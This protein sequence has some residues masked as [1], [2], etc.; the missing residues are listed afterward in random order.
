M[1]TILVVTEIRDGQLKNI[2]YEVFAAANKLAEKTN[3]NV[4]A[5]LLGSNLSQPAEIPGKY[6]VKQVII[7]ELEVL[8]SIPG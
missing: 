3:L 1:S 6:G 2:N 7:A 4:A 8:G 5:L